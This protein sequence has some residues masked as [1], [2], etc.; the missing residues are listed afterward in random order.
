MDHPSVVVWELTRACALACRHCRASAQPERDPGEL[1][2]A[3]A[4]AFVDQIARL[5]PPVFVLSGGDPLCRPDLMVILR[6]AALRG[7][8]PTLSP[9]ATEQFLT[10]D[11]DEIRHLGVS[12]IA[13]SLD[14]ASSEIHDRFRGTRGTWKRTIQA[15]H[16]VRAAGVPLQINTTIFRGNFAE[17]EALLELVAELQPAAW[18][19]FQLVPLGRGRLADCL[20]AQEMEDFF[21]WLYPVSKAVPF[22]VNVTEG[23]HFRRV[24]LQ[25]AGGLDSLRSRTPRGVGDG[26]RFAFI[27]HTGG[28][29]PSGFLP[30]PQGDIRRDDLLQVYHQSSVF[31]ALRDP[32]RL[33][34]K[35]G[36]C[37]FREVCGGSRSRAYAM[38]GDAFAS[39]PLCVYEPA[40]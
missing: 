15:A 20:T 31:Q 8:R 16:A 28:I 25:Q 5:A 19:L 2:T 11:L 27:S 34:G 26:K 18:N 1:T 24:V 32:A 29:F 14:S 23:N 12:R 37:E 4:L 36:R 7:L 40:G 39:D 17:R 9:S 13:V 35:C 38:E 10:L 22:A 21:L 6:H 33:S 3:E 30:W